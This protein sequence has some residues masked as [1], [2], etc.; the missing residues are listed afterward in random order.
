MKNIFITLLAALTIFTT[1]SK[2]V[3][4]DELVDLIKCRPVVLTPDLS[5]SLTLSAGGIAG[6]T[7]IKVERFYLGRSTTQTY[8]VRQLDLNTQQEDQPVIFLGED[9]SF[10]AD[11]SAVTNDGGAPGILR[12][13]MGTN[14]F[15]IEELSCT[16]IRD[17]PQLNYVY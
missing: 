6:L 14:D 8:V 5:M 16:V 4:A 10:E 15:S 3:A 17:N 11:F 1:A 12:L 7:M 2:A 13:R 9:I